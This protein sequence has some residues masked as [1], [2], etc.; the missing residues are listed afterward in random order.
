MSSTSVTSK[1]KITTLFEDTNDYSPY[2]RYTALITL[3]FML[4][5]S[6]TFPPFTTILALAAILLPSVFASKWLWPAI[7]VTAVITFATGSIWTYDNHEWAVL[8]WMFTLA[9]FSF[10]RNDE[11][12]Q[13][14]A[15]LLIGFIFLFAT[16]WKIAA[17]E[18]RTGAFFELTGHT[19]PRFTDIMI[20]FGLM[21]EAAT[22]NDRAIS[23]WGDPEYGLQ[24]FS[25]ITSPILESF[26]IFLTIGTYIVEGGLALL[27]LWPL[28]KKFT[29]LRDL[30]LTV[31]FIGTYVMVPVSGFGNLLAVM[32][33][34]ASNIELK[35]RIALYA[36]LIV[37]MEVIPT[38]MLIL[39][40]FGIGS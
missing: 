4:I 11:L 40:F 25:L 7:F 16:S 20:A 28:V 23:R 18:F 5:N 22:T 19:E 14:T 6:S 2:F 27:F 1:N 24:G 32:G 21:P 39:S 15:R 13:R 10:V 3:V 12:L 8:Y 36:G 35:R 26:W 38:R 37:L 31:F 29:W 17:S 9:I 34:A 33:F 30:A